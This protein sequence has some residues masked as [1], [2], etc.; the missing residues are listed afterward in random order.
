MCGQVLPSRES[1]ATFHAGKGGGQGVSGPGK[2]RLGCAGWR[3][4]KTRQIGG[5]QTG[6][7]VLRVET[8]EV[9]PFQQ[10]NVTS[11]ARSDCA[12]PTKYKKSWPEL[13]DEKRVGIAGDSCHNHSRLYLVED[14]NG[15]YGSTW[16]PDLICF[17]QN[18]K[19]ELASFIKTEKESS[20]TPHH[21][22]RMGKEY[23][24]TY[25]H[26]DTNGMLQHAS[27]CLEMSINCSQIIQVVWDH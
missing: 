17:Q 3:R 27:H 16:S 11:Q 1:T 4:S 24:H 8:K 6:S 21:H 20:L 15:T 23:K 14:A 22:L 10:Q 18:S 12:Q 25:T 9:K 7:W 26:S 2:V 19:A 5:E 13:G